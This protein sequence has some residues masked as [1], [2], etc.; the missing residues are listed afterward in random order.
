M[1]PYVVGSFIG[2]GF[3]VLAECCLSGYR[4]A[5]RSTPSEQS[6]VTPFVDPPPGLEESC[7]SDC[8]PQEPVWVASP[9][10]VECLCRPEG[11]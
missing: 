10:G 6:P 1:K 9:K 11:C 3:C 2:V 4:P 7:V 8:G 5:D